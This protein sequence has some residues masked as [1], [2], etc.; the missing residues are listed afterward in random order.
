[1][2]KKARPAWAVRLQAERDARPWNKHQMARELLRAVGD[3]TSPVDSLVRQISRWEAGKHF[4][5]D[6][7]A[8]YATAFGIAADEL[9]GRQGELPLVS[10][11]S[12][13]PPADP[14]GSNRDRDELL[15]RL[16]MAQA[17]DP[18]LAHILKS[19]TEMIRLL[20]RRLGNVAAAEKMR[21]HITQVEQALRYSVSGQVRKLLAGVLADSSALAGWQAIDM[22]ALAVAWDHFE[23]AKV[24]AREAEDVA[25]LAFATGEQAYVLVDLHRP[26]DAHQL[27]S[28][29]LAAHYGQVPARLRCWLKMAEAEIAAAL[30]DEDLCHDALEAAAAVLPSTDADPDLP[31]LAL[32]GSHIA[33]WRGNCLVHFGDPE[34][35][36]DLFAALEGIRPRSFA[37]AEAGL[38]CDLASALLMQGEGR[39]ARA[40]I[41]LAGELA[42]LTGSVRQ[43]RRIDLLAAQ[44]TQAGC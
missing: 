33:R 10:G 30:D 42:A 15:Q 38:R 18:E 19:E 40:Q 14:Y 31:F 28:E 34:I 20:D 39:E 29:T 16:H 6:W 41:S 12:A 1:M 35:T 44:L 23:R 36:S 25:L 21:A 43:Q 3:E 17:V 37:R 2:T 24:A 5:R 11:G 9:F 27:V 7:Q 13:G 26:K 22:G 32:N 8:A 4:P